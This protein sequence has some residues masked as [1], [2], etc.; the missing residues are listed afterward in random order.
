MWVSLR[1]CCRRRRR[2]RTQLTSSITAPKSVLD[3]LPVAQGGAVDSLLERSTSRKIADRES[4]YQVRIALLRLAAAL[5]RRS[6][7]GV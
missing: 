3:S 2:A 4:Q 5:R 7:F 1:L 6:S